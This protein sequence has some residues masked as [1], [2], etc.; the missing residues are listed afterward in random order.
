MLRTLIRLAISTTIGMGEVTPDCNDED[1]WACG[2]VLIALISIP[3]LF[4]AA[5][6]GGAIWAIT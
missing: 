3:V 6:I 2:L 5:G 1:T 4:A